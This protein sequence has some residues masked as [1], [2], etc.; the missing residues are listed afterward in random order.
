MMCVTGKG[1][2]ILLDSDTFNYN[3]TRAIILGESAAITTSMIGLYQLWYKDYPRTSFHSFD[4]SREWLQMDKVGHGM[5][6]YALGYTNYKLLK[7]AGV[8]ERPSNWIGGSVGLLFLSLVEVQD[9]YSAQWGFSWSDMAA[10]LSGY[11]FF[12]LQQEIW[13]E[14]RIVLKYSYNHSP[15]QQ[16]R[17]DLLGNRNF[18]ALLKDYNG[19]TYWASCNISS[20]LKEESGFPKWLN[21]ALGYSGYGMTGGN[22]NP[23]YLDA[24]GLASHTFD[25]RRQFLLAPDIDLTK[26]PVKKQWLKDV[27]FAL[28]FLK[29]PAPTIELNTGQG[30]TKFKS[31]WLYF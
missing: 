27:L 31:Y 10:N 12:T 18:N 15:Y 8:K 24:Q 29:F 16:Y 11:L 3:R 26:I 1:Q 28:N 5:S 14:Q 13:K 20:F 30:N 9:A 25:R 17:P 19:Q 2:S 6:A 22:Y 7:W 23:I 21:L 4:D